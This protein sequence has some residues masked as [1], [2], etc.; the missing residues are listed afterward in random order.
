[1]YERDPTMPKSRSLTAVPFVGKDVPSERSE[2]A[3]PG[4]ILLFVLILFI[5]LSVLYFDK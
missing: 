3:H 2:F 4:I 1:M 5:H